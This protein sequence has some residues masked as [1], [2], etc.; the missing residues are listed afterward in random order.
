MNMKTE[1]NTESRKLRKQRSKKA[2]N[3]Q[4]QFRII[5]RN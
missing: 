4:L 5:S 3:P 2:T 1:E